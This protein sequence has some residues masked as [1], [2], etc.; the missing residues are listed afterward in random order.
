MDEKTI[1]AI[2]M[3]K[4]IKDLEKRLPQK[5]L[6]KEKKLAKRFS[7]DRSAPIKKLRKLYSFMDELYAFISPHII[8][9][10]GCSYCCY[11]PISISKLEAEYINMKT[12]IP[13]T[14]D[15]SVL[16]ITETKCPFLHN[17]FCQIYEVR[18]FACRHHVTL[19]DTAKWCT[20]DCC[21]KVEVTMLSFSGIR[22]T[23]TLIISEGFHHTLKD[24]RK[25]FLPVQGIKYMI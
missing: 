4:R 13:I 21:D 10:K 9:K 5:L 23:Y 6:T 19:Y 7:K 8:C 14:D 12:G 22:E 25:Y 2:F 15:M 20:P 16:S 18:P 3:K 1:S 11:Y 17:A 24:I